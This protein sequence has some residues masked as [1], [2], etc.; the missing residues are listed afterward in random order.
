M[1][2]TFGRFFSRRW[3]PATILVVFGVALCT[4][5]GF[6]QLDR[7][8][9]RRA[10][11]SRVQAQ[12]DLPA[13]TLNDSLGS[14]GDPLPDLYNMEYRAVTVTGVYDHSQEIAIANQSWAND[15]GVHLI[16]PLIIDGS[17][18]A[19]LVDRG[20]IPGVEYQTGDWSKYQH[21]GEV[22]V[23]GILRRPQTVATWGGR[24]DAPLIDGEPRRSTWNFV[25]IEQIQKQTSRML[26]GAYIQESPDPA[27]TGLPY[28]SVAKVEISEGPHMGY[29]L[30]WFAFAA[31]L[32]LGY[33]FF[34][35]RQERNSRA[36]SPAG[37]RPIYD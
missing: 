13:L 33:P 36:T 21:P 29:A 20:W 22:T 18:Q 3:L 25:N 7:L 23:T 30:Q 15:W 27:W 28:R 4:R 8:E 24:T 10:F 32:G 31:V 34:V 2:E 9:A 1:L 19:I 14:S 37:A 5:L 11:N 35:R 12:I 16:T 17:E 26:L 6:W